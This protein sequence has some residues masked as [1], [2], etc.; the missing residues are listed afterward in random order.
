MGV[1]KDVV[2][3]EI[4]D[5][6]WI[7][8]HQTQAE[9][10]AVTSGQTTDQAVCTSQPGG[11]YTFGNN[12]NY[13]GCA[14]ACWCCVPGTDIHIY[15]HNMFTRTSRT[16]HLYPTFTSLLTP[17]LTT[18]PT[19]HFSSH[20]SLLIPHLTSHPTSHLSPHTSLLTPHLTHPTPH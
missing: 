8:Y 18:D 6:N 11:V 13:Q 1:A 2:S 19:P 3:L 15:I 5:A 7:C 20:T 14:S 12:A 10:N 4:F 16:S 9:V 17:H